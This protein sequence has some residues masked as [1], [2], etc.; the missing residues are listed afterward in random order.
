MR[1]G[2]IECPRRSTLPNIALMRLSSWHKA[3]G[4]EVILHATSLDRPDTVYI[5][6]LF[7]WQRRDVEQAAA[8]FRPH[9]DVLIGGP[10]MLPVPTSLPAEVD[11]MPNDYELFGVDFGIGYSSRG[12]IRHC[13]FCPVPK[14]EGHLREA[15]A[16][17]NL[18]NPRSNRLLLLDNNFFASDW[19]P[20]V[21]EIRARDLHVCWPQGLDIRLLDREQALA[22]ADLHARGQLWNQRF[23]RRGGLHFSWDNP[24]TDTSSAEVRR[25]VQLLF[26]VGF[27]PNDLTFYVLIGFGSTAEEEVARLDTLHQLGI[28]PKVMVYRDPG[29]R[30]RRDPVRMD[31]QHWNDGHVWRHAHFRDYR[32]RLAS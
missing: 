20:K 5:S 31:I 28:Q 21:V 30:D 15:S 26:D 9:A 16:I 7:T 17:G 12:C 14:I 1:I 13:A 2:L 19:R 23:T 25:G 4:D 18:L 32:R 24:L 11:A 27:G 10:G 29:E 6:T 22:L 3:L 8:H